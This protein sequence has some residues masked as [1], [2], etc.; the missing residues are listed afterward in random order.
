VNASL[1]RQAGWSFAISL[2]VLWEAWARTRHEPTPHKLKSS[3]T[4]PTATP[5]T[6]MIALG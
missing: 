2:V 3:P 4:C 1:G 6:R 5:P